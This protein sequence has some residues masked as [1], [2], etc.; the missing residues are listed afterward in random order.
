ME[1]EYDW[2][3]CQ[4]EEEITG[5]MTSQVEKMSFVTVYRKMDWR[6]EPIIIEQ[7]IGGREKGYTETNQKSREY[8]T[9]AG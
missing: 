2:S 6:I 8:Y 5:K 9:V 3:E 1:R 7:P 4:S